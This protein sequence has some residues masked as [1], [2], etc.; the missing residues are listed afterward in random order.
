MPLQRQ[1]TALR[2]DA[3]TLHEMR[4]ELR[5]DGDGRGLSLDRAR[6]LA[7]QRVARPEQNSRPTLCGA[8]S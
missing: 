4:S 6:A 2:V 5:D 1:A 3:A 7:I 8:H